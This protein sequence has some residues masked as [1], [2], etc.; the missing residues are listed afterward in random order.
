MLNLEII[1][2]TLE[3]NSNKNISS[4]LLKKAVISSIKRN[5]NLS[6]S[7]SVSNVIED[8]LRNQEIEDEEK[9]Q[10]FV[11]LKDRAYKDYEDLKKEVEELFSSSSNKEEE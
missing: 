4:L 1:K 2:Q 6:V 11:I 3:N 5:M 8:I 10:L 9:A 7:Y